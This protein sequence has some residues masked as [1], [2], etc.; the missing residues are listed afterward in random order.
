L[1]NKRVLYGGEKIGKI[2]EVE[3]DSRKL[4]GIISKNQTFAYVLKKYDLRDSR[5]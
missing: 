2:E 1:K 5:L 4:F 3:K